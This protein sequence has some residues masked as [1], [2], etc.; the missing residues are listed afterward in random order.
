[1]LK[2]LIKPMQ[3]LT[4]AVIIACMIQIGSVYADHIVILCP[5]STSPQAIINYSYPIAVRVISS[6]MATLKNLKINIL[7]S[8]NNTI[9]EL[10]SVDRKNPNGAFNVTTFWH[11]DPEKYQPGIH[12][13]EFEKNLEYVYNGTRVPIQE[14]EYIGVDVEN[15]D[16]N[17]T[18]N[19]WCPPGSASSE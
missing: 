2:T 15:E 10:T 14:M 8:S 11:V 7:S 12:Y 17:N 16:V 4:V 19:V 1:M 13:I 6:D 3:L 18:N 5:S 9:E